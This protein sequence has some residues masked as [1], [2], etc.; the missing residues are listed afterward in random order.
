[1]SITINILY[2]GK[3]GNARKFVEEMVSTGVVEEIRSEVGNERYEYYF[4]MEN[5]EAVLLIDRWKDE[6]A[7]DLHHKSKMMSKISKLRKKYK[8]KMKIERYV[9]L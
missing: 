8:L 4:P 7:I 5:K 6:K 9:D 3:N 2:A 1:M